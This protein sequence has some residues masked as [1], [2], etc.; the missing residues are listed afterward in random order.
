MVDSENL[1]G[2]DE[3][4]ELVGLSSFLGQFL[5]AKEFCQITKIF[6][7]L[8]LRMIAECEDGE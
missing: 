5:T 4:K 7:N 8:A 1:I 6:D 3:V 2:V